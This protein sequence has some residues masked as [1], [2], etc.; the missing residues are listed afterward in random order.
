MPDGTAQARLAFGADAL[1]LD[2]GAEVARIDEALR[3]G[4]LRR[5]RKRGVVVGVSGGIDSSVTA[6][7]CAHALGP[8]RVLAVLMPERDSDPASAALGRKLAEK[9][10]IPVVVEDIAPALEALG[11]YARR[12]A[13]IRAVVPEF[14]PGWGCKVVL[15]AAMRARGYNISALVVQA[16]DGSTQRHRLP[17]DAYLA[18]IAAANMKQRTR[19]LIE[20]THADRLNHAVAGTPNRLED[21]QG[22]FVKNG[23]G[24]ADIKPIAHL[25]KT[26]VYQLAEHLGLPEEIRRRPPT[27]DT[28]SMPQSQDEYFF[29]VDHATL[30]LCLA[31]LERGVPAEAAAQATSLSVAAVQAVWR[32]IAAKRRVAEYLHAAALRIERG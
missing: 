16:P 10:G 25:F 31:A 6:A 13:A 2:S 9:L 29:S 19:K 15:D 22:F 4:V 24:A 11:C 8:D 20:Y 5:L 26:Q 18:V 23:D 3:D 17:L 21:D 30:D 27:T 7:L 28:W 32:D 12:D 14:G 1:R